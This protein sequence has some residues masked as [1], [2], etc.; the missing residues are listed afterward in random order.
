VKA[1]AADRLVT[2]REGEGVVK[3][4]SFAAPRGGR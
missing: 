3:A 1:V 2:I 4:E